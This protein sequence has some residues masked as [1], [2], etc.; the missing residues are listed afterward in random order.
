MRREQPM[1]RGQIWKASTGWKIRY[2]DAAGKRH[3]E[4]HLLKGDAVAKLEEELRRA[5]LGDLWQSRKQVTL[6]ELVDQFLRQYPRPPQ[7]K[8]RITTE[9]NRA[10]KVFGKVPV[11]QLDPASIA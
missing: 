11:R 6:Q 3:Q 8:A 10:T 1:Q 4:T 7:T 2:Y 5:R 9:L